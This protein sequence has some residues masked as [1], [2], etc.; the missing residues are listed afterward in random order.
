MKKRIPMTILR[1]LFSSEVG[2]GESRLGHPHH[3]LC[4]C[5]IALLIAGI[6]T[7]AWGE[8]VISPV[9]FPGGYKQGIHY[10]TV[11]RG[12][13]REELFTS[14]EAIEAARNHLPLPQGTVIMMEDYREDQLYRYIAMVKIH[15]YG[16]SQPEDIRNGDWAFQSLAPDGSINSSENVARC[17]ACHKDQ[18]DSDYVFTYG[19][20]QT[21]IDR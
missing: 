14:R 2:Q 20:M 8:K 15:G 1:V 17:M 11:K 12:N 13:I 19:R 10:A 21:A 3:R 5:I 7:L 16:K 6:S 18:S 4:I 9:T